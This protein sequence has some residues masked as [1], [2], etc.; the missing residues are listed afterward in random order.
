MKELFF[1]V[2]LCTL[3]VLGCNK[4]VDEPNPEPTPNPTPQPQPEKVE[5]K[6]RSN[7]EALGEIMSGFSNVKTYTLISSTDTLAA[8][9]GFIFG[10]TPDGSGL[11]KNPD[12]S[13]YVMINNHE[14]LW[15]VSRLYLDNKF[16]PVRGEY[17][18]NSDGGM[19]RL[20][21]GTLAT[22][23]EH[24][25]AKPTFLSTGESNIN[26]MTH[27]IDPLGS[28]DPASQS[29]IKPA[30]GKFSGE[31]A[32]P[33]RKDAY[34]GKTVVI[35]GEDDPNGQVYLYVSDAP[36][37]LDNGKLY[38]LRR[39]DKNA[40]ETDMVKGRTYDVEF[41]EIP[42]AKNLTGP[43]I[44]SVNKNLK[45]VQFG[46]VEDLDYRK[47]G[48][49]ASR[50]IFFSATGVPNQ[51]EKTTWGRV[52]NLKLDAG[53]PFSGQL[54]IIADG[55]DNPGSDLVNPDNICATENYVYIQEDGSN[56]YSEAKHDSYIWQYD[57]A[58]GTKKPFM[59]MR[60][61]ALSG[62]RFNPAKDVRLGT[63]EYGAMVDVS[64]IVGIPGTFTLNLQPHTWVEENRFINPSKATAVQPYKAGGQIVV[65]ANVPR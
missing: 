23:E 41:A 6:N 36:G 56:Y 50:S 5:L 63:W 8:T 39:K 34:S 28:A 46:R 35:L 65:L 64:D 4:P 31:N 37:D 45:A 18:V 9:P 3:L 21:S 7:T 27:A 40:V 42:N 20:C 15:S 62:T 58:A 19:F 59:T 30:L 48:G 2:S 38:S 55:A 33:L 29:R 57:I 32:V 22:P 11:L 47:G 14:N 1:G 43:E 49:A 53:S 24:G 13:G 17:L 60:N 52:Y 16:N 10:G 61:R 44:E 26:A 25:F 54:T 51:P 12:G